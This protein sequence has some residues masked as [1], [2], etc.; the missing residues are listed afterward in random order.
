[1]LY[2][3]SLIK[4]P[5]YRPSADRL[6]T[7]LDAHGVRY[8]LLDGAR[9]IWLRD[10]MPVRRRDGKYVSFRYEPSYLRGY[11]HLR[12]DF[13][14]DICGQLRLPDSGTDPIIYSDINLDGGNVVF[15]P[16]REKGIIS[17]RVFTENPERDRAGLVRELEELLEARIILIPSLPS[18]MTGH[19][20]GMVRFLDEDTVAGNAAPFRHGLEGRVKAAL[21]R[22]G[23]TV[24][25]FPYFF[26]SQDSAEGCYLNWL[27][28]EGCI[29]LPVFG[30]VLD[31]EA[32]RAAEQLF[33]KTVVPVRFNEIAAEGGC[34]NC[35]SWELD[36]YETRQSLWLGKEK[37]D[38]DSVDDPQRR[39][40]VP[41]RLPHLRGPERGQH[42]GDPGRGPV[43]L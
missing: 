24:V 26:R 10:F 31:G 7:A 2:F 18:D 1:M 41:L 38:G 37:T 20:D 28:T 36:G 27:E 11:S 16:S 12:T 22:E 43:A 4:S 30:H 40:G 34:L 33:A 17:D 25:D 14:R 6:F 23:L 35:V 5:D 19:A 3:S 8:G 29:F 39:D 15:S 42:R 9:D 13:R 21:A 32:V